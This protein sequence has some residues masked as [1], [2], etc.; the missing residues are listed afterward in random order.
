[1]SQPRLLFQSHNRRRLGHLM[2]GLNIARA[3]RQ[4][5]PTSDLL[6]YARSTSA[7]CLC[8]SEFRAYVE[9]DASGTSHWPELVRTFV[10]DAV[11]YDTLLPS[12]PA[13]EP[14]APLR[15]RGDDWQDRVWHLLRRAEQSLA[16]T[17]PC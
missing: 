14:A 13:Q 3:I 11:V 15:L 17:T 1:V 12:D 7:E 4:L 5:A 8:R 2:R 16:A 10:P 6:F 9:T